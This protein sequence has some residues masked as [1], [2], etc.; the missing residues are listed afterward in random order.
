LELANRLELA[1]IKSSEELIEVGT[2][3]AFIRLRIVFPDA[4]HNQ[5]YALEVAIQG[6]RWHGI[7]KERK[8]E[9]QEF[10]AMIKNDK[11]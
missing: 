7:S 2:E 3:K 6:I 9:L 11:I 10:F 5:L 4:C 8:A 1:G